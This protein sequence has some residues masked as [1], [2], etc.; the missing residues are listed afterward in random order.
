MHRLLQQILLAV[1]GH[2]LLAV[3]HHGAEARLGQ[4]STESGAGG[5]DLL[6]QRALGLQG[7][8]QLTGIHLV[9]GV[10]VGADM[11]GDK[12]FH[13]MVGDEFAN[14]HFRIGGVVADDGEILH[15]AGNQFVNQGDRVANTQKS[16]DHYGHAVVNF[17]GGFFY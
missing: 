15:I 11:G 16:S 1:N 2:F 5:A 12:F 4:H 9:D 6:G 3:F 13:L 8:L 14:T 7:H 10:V 17:V